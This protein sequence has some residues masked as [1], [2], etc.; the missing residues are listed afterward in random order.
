MP[1][2]FLHLML[3][4][5]DLEKSLEFYVGAMG[6]RVLRRIE[7]PDEGRRAAFVG[8]GEEI[9]ATVLELTYRVDRTAG[10]RG[11]ALGHLAIGCDDVIGLCQALRSHGISIDSEPRVIANGKTIAFVTDPDG[12]ALELVQPAGV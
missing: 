1:L 2:R 12:N 10:M 5:S 4:V 9:E 7:A 6:M 11:D 3:N 8:Y